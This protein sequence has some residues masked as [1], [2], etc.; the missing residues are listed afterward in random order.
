[1]FL[2]RLIWFFNVSVIKRKFFEIVYNIGLKFNSLQNGD[3]Y[4][5][6]KMFNLDGI[7]NENNKEHNEKWPHILDHPYR[8]LITR[9]SGSGT[10][11]DLL[12]FIKKQDSDSLIDKFYLYA[13]D[14]NELKH[15]FLIKK[16]EDVEIK[17]L[18][19]SKAMYG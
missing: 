17:H 12:N 2:K 16:R 3:S 11:N 8:M 14:L 7:T 5:F 18:N 10:T 15:Q 9:D 13:K 19:H 4:T 1:M 6:Q